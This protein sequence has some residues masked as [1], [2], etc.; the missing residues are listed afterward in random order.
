M[1]WKAIHHK[2]LVLMHENPIDTKA[3]NHSKEPIMAHRV[4]GYT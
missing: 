1:L 4:N 3:Y 2:N